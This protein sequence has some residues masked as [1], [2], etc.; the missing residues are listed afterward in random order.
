[1]RVFLLDALI[2][3]KLLVLDGLAVMLMIWVCAYVL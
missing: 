3:M 2:V 1:M